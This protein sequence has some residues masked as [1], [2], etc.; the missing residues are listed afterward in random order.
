MSRIHPNV[1]DDL[2]RLARQARSMTLDYLLAE[3]AWPSA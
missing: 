2:H 1:P 3:I